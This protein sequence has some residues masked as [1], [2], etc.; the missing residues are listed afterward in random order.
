MTQES[1]LGGTEKPE[2]T[3]TRKL[4][5]LD[6]GLNVYSSL[7][8]DEEII[9]IPFA[10]S[11]YGTARTVKDFTQTYLDELNHNE[12][13]EVLGIDFN[14]MT[15]VDYWLNK[16]DKLKRDMEALGTV[17]MKEHGFTVT[18]IDFTPEF[19]TDISKAIVN[20]IIEVVEMLQ[21]INQKIDN[22]PLSLY[23]NFYRY[24]KSRCDRHSVE[25]R[26]KQFKRDAG[27]LTLGSLMDKQAFE[28]EECLKKKLL[29]HTRV[30]S[31]REVEQMNLEK[32][33]K[34]LPYG[35]V[36]PEE[37]KKCYAR[38]FRFVLQDDDMLRIDYDLYGNYLFQYYYQLSEEERQDLIELDIM[39]EMI[40]EDMMALNTMILPDVLA[41]PEGRLLLEKAR[42][43]GYLDAHYQPKLSNTKSAMLADEIATRLKIRNRWKVFEQFWNRHDMYKDNYEG[44]NQKQSLSFLDEIRTVLD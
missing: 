19:T 40:N 31:D 27:V 32:I 2:M 8:K 16:C 43:A 37:L 26:Y 20:I 35:Y 17:P 12:C 1:K 41:T 25:T 39:L 21:V 4:I 42:E 7:H 5:A 36:I 33:N 11:L 14:K 23:G 6:E 38:F 10:F 3:L 28:I 13:R 29:R 9:L 18:L 44:R 30:P 34:H 15:S 24:Q 22:A